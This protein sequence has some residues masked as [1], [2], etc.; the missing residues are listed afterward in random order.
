[1]PRTRS[2]P[3]TEAKFLAA[4]LDLLA[5][6]GCR[7]LGIN[8]VAQRAGADKVLIYRYFGG[9]EGL[10]LRVAESREWLPAPDEVLAA[11][12]SPPGSSGDLLRQ[13]CSRV[14]SH[15]EA[16]PSARQ[17][18]L[19]RRAGDNALTR[20]FGLAWARFWDELADGL[21]NG[22]GTELR[23]AWREACLLGALLVEAELAGERV[24][25]AVFG[26]VAAGLEPGAVA[27]V[28]AASSAEDE[29]RLPTNLL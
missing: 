2:R 6:D 10:L 15:F 3:R 24:D 28:A 14:V 23:G 1:M 9:L 20:H 18:L 11:A 16:D 21:S 5:E 13:A 4:V 17:A 12:G 19:W 27:N 22:L 7:R 26:R 25:A 29:D 8:A